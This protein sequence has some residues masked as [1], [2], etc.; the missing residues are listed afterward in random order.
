MRVGAEGRVELAAEA[1]KVGRWP[2]L[3][4]VLEWLSMTGYWGGRQEQGKG[5]WELTFADPSS[6][7]TLSPCL[8]PCEGHAYGN[9]V[10]SHSN[11]VNLGVWKQSL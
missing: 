6:L 7:E 4:C 3:G 8:A 5:I 10:S 9:L 11:P 1:T 2:C